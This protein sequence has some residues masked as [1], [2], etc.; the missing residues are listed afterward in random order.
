LYDAC[1]VLEVH[2]HGPG[3]LEEGALQRKATRYRL[4]KRL[5]ALLAGKISWRWAPKF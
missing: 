5:K 1:G 4:N 2:R 3:R